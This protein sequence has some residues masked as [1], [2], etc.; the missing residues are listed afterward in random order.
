MLAVLPGKRPGLRAFR[1]CFSKCSFSDW[2]IRL[3]EH[4]SSARNA[5]AHPSGAAPAACPES[6]HRARP[7]RRGS[8]ENGPQRT[9]SKGLSG[10]FATCNRVASATDIWRT[11]RRSGR[12]AGPLW[13]KFPPRPRA[14]PPLHA[15]E[16]MRISR[17][18]QP[19]IVWGLSGHLQNMGRSTGLADYAAAFAR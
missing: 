17:W 11:R 9:G 18:I 1:V 14:S 4:F 2:I 19:R 3:R 7:R 10:I 12:G 15:V 6:Q 8:L 5:G 16:S 13:R